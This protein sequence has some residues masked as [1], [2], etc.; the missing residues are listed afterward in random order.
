M[1]LATSL[2][3]CRKAVAEE[4]WLRANLRVFDGEATD[5]Y[6]KLTLVLPLLGLYAQLYATHAF[7]ATPQQSNAGEEKAIQ[8][9]LVWKELCEHKH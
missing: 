5:E 3:E 4:N 7:R 9:P 2:T 6:D 8:H 1:W